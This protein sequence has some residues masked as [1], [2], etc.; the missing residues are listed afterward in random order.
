MGECSRRP[1]RPLTCLCRA[2]DWT[3]LIML[4]GLFL[5]RFSFKFSVWFRVVEISWL[6]VSFCLHV[7][8]TVLYHINNTWVVV[9]NDKSTGCGLNIYKYDCVKYKWYHTIPSRLPRTTLRPIKMAQC[10]SPAKMGRNDRECI[11]V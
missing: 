2:L 1:D 4:I 8:Y 7:K 3:G 10:A 6:P 5:V 9:V 11:Q